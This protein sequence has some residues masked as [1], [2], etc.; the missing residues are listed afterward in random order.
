MYGAIYSQICRYIVLVSH[1]SHTQRMPQNEH[2]FS[3]HPNNNLF[4][5]NSSPHTLHQLLSIFSSNKIT[6]V[7]Q[8]VQHVLS[9]RDDD[10][11]DADDDN[12]DADGPSDETD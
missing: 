12:G 3:S 9:D 11:G 8:L 10:D 6:S 4:S 7:G 1:N 5:H 2:S